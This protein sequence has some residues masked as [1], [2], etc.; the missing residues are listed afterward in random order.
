MIV[1]TPINFTPSFFAKK[2]KKSYHVEIG[3]GFKKGIPMQKAQPF[4]NLSSTGLKRRRE[5]M[6]TPSNLTGGGAF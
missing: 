6:F 4:K 2:F 1:P 5:E 3:R